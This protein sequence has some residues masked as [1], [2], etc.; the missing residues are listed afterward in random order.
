MGQHVDIDDLIDST[1]AARLLDL[2]SPNVVSAYR[3]R[4]PDFPKPVLG[5]RCARWLRQDVERWRDTRKPPED[6]DSNLINSTE[7]ARVLGVSSGNVVSIYRWRYP[8]FPK[9]VAGANRNIRWLREDIERWRDA[10][11]PG[12]QAARRPTT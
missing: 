8:D 4:Y 2:S 3:G 6:I 10:R 7:A 12:S 9:P 1:E 11:T 5:G